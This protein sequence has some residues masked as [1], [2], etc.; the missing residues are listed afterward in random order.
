[1]NANTLETMGFDSV[2]FY[3]FLY[4]LVCLFWFWR[5]SPVLLLGASL[6]FYAGLDPRHLP[7]LL[8]LSALAWFGAPHVAKG[9]NPWILR[10]LI[11]LT[12]LPLAA[13]KLAIAASAGWA[14]PLGLSFYAF[15]CVSYLVDCHRGTAE[16]ERSAKKLFL[17]V[18][19]FPQLVAGPITRAREML[20]QFD[21]LG[22][23]DGSATR[24]SLWRI[25]LG[26]LKKL[27]IAN[28]TGMLALEV[29]AH[30]GNYNGYLVLFA[31]FAGRYFIYA[32]FSGYTDIALGSAALLGLRLPENFLR[33]FAATSIA[34]YW[35][36][37]HITLQAW[38]RDYVFF[39]L[40]GSS[41]GAMVG[42][43]PLVLLTFVLLGAWHGLS[44]N[45]LLYGLWHGAFLV[46]HDA[47]RGARMR[48]WASLGVRDGLISSWIFPWATFV[49]LVCPPTVLFLTQTPADALAV[50]HA[51]GQ[52]VGRTWVQNLR[53][54]HFVTAELSI[55]FVE[56]FQWLSAR[57]DCL[58]QYERLPRPVRWLAL[59]GALGWLVFAAELGGG[60]G[61]L[62]FQF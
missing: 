13:L 40:A 34:D 20:P 30:P 60:R 58:A 19:F 8:S 6:L 45:F 31:V 51:L 3:F 49:L 55:L 2:G 38:I 22:R 46:L 24:R 54:Y 53:W 36:R 11:A 47:T 48:L 29:F 44:W 35:R 62:Y 56:V 61:F 5:A 37:W 59:V 12:L 27:A 28:V 17:Y 23:P 43:Y 26:L 10:G 39:P 18:A 21:R 50:V 42:T 14:L 41:L 7:L 33:P 32:D 52:G 15:H 25:Y 4:A 1:M 16:P 9:R 57:T